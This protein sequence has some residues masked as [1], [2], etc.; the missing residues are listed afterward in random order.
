MSAAASH[1]AGD[2]L[3]IRPADFHSN[4]ETLASNAFQSRSLVEAATGRPAAVA[5]CERLAA[6]LEAAGVGVHLYD[7]SADPSKPDAVFPNNWVSFHRDGTVVLY[8][9]L[10][11]NR[12]AERRIDLLLDLVAARGFRMERLVDLSHHE[13]Q[14]R[15]LEGTG[16]LVL[17]RT[18]RI[19]YGCRSPRTDPDVAREFAEELR[20]ELVLFDARDTSGVAVYHTN[21]MMALGTRFAVVC[22][23]AVDAAQRRGI[24]ERLR[25]S[26][27]DLIALTVAQMHA[28]A[29]N[30]LELS[31]RDGGFIV[32]MSAA[33]YQALSAGQRAAIERLSG[34]IVR[35][36]VPT[37][38]TL[39]GGS[40][41]C[42]IA[43]VF[44]PVRR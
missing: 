12:R 14:G 2:V 3:M 16:S 24:E 1:A 41:R 9:M 15:Y 36:P 26:G 13:L 32:A 35:T 27:R 11:R 29:G 31:T 19:A 6:A 23:D 7:D 21:V 28:F 25:A 4:P 43:E 42:M 40:V 18:C 38:E 17:D 33:A 30:I 39:G 5:E 37:I 44:L 22:L 34:R 20:Y 10:S 8:P